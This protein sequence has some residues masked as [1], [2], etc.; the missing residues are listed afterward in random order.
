MFIIIFYV[1]V[2]LFFII[3]YIIILYIF[4]FL[5]HYHFSCTLSF[6]LYIIIFPVHYHPVHYRFVYYR[7]VYHRFSCTLSFFLYLIIFPVHYHPVHY[8]LV[9]YRF[10]CTLSFFLYIIIFPVH[11][12][13]VH[14]RFEYYRL[15]RH[16]SSCTLSFSPYI[17]ILYI[18]VLY[19]IVSYVIVFL[20]HYNFSCALSSCT[21]SFRILS[22]RTSP[23]FL[24]INSLYIIVLYIIIFFI[25]LVHYWFPCTLS[26]FFSGK[27]GT[28]QLPPKIYS[29]FNILVPISSEATVVVKKLPSENTTALQIAT[30]TPLVT[31]STGITSSSSLSSL[32]VETAKNISSSPLTMKSEPSF[33]KQ[34]TNLETTSQEIISLDS[35][36]VKGITS[37]SNIEDRTTSLFGI[38]PQETQVELKVLNTTTKLPDSETEYL[39][40]DLVS[41]ATSRRSIPETS[42][43]LHVL[44]SNNSTTFDKLTISTSAQNESDTTKDYITFSDQLGLISTLPE[45]TTTYIQEQNTNRLNSSHPF[46]ETDFTPH[47][48]NELKTTTDS[49]IVS[50]DV[51]SHLPSSLPFS[52]SSSFESRSEIS[53]DAALSSVLWSSTLTPLM[54]SASCELDLES[55]TISSQLISEQISTVNS[56]I[57]IQTSQ[58]NPSWSTQSSFQTSLFSDYLT[59]DNFSVNIFESSSISLSPTLASGIQIP[60]S[61]RITSTEITTVQSSTTEIGTSDRYSDF[62]FDSSRSTEIL[63]SPGS[64]ENFL[65]TS[66]RMEDA[67]TS[68]LQSDI[69]STITT[70]SDLIFT[71]SGISS[72]ANSVSARGYHGVV[73]VTSG[74]QWQKELSHK[75]TEQYKALES[76]M[77][78][79]VSI[80][81][82]KNPGRC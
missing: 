60:A 82:D 69:L 18:I 33:T 3:L 32:T 26:F 13:P 38:P 27:I 46:T 42:P 71:S 16:R 2:F 41:T 45:V 31:L 29:T 59:Q 35:N 15:V 80:L 25:I 73:K 53:S 39:T 63:T 21:L 58:T 11:Y 6:S 64:G 19:I 17:I 65:S 67:S 30:L 43:S 28:A 36:T 14:Y 40:R 76:K 23:F 72:T 9:H 68:L 49:Q 24:Y 55:Q 77:L 7:L 61:M 79:F 4:I 62:Y 56:E 78:K 48:Q 37:A 20:V 81:T 5:V 8:H 10:S 34:M 57:I 22:S 74:A 12:H 75:N 50:F 52:T 70:G 44:S 51:S 47:K 54:I 66:I 1:I